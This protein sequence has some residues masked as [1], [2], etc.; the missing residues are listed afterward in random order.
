MV[1][2]L[3][4]N[5]QKFFQI[6]KKKNQNEIED[7]DKAAADEARRLGFGNELDELL[8]CS[9]RYDLLNKH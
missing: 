7:Q 4:R 1:K 8:I 9:E 6:W 5:L 2:T 3:S